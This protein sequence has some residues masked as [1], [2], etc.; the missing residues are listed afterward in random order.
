MYVFVGF[1][2]STIV[3]ILFNRDR[4]HQM[5][6]VIELVNYLGKNLY[7]FGV[8]C[9]LNREWLTQFR[10]YRAVQRSFVHFI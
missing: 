7:K 1:F 5:D 10:E 8:K 3:R 9:Q 6:I 4:N 2:P